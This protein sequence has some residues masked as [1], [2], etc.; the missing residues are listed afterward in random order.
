MDEEH[1]EEQVIKQIIMENEGIGEAVKV[2][3]IAE[4][5]SD[6][7]WDFWSIPAISKFT[8]IPESE[9][10]TF[11]NKNP[12]LFREAMA[13]DRQGHLLFTLRSRPIKLREYLASLKAI[14]SH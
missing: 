1:K 7:T 11:L 8:G 2:N 14:L 10:L 13:P 9:V 5:L 12:K 4:A 3:K 6:P